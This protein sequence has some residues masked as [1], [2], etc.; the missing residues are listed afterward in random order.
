[1]RNQT[2][3]ILQNLHSFDQDGGNPDILRG[4]IRNRQLVEDKSANSFR[5]VRP[6]AFNQ[7]AILQTSRMTTRITP[8]LQRTS[9]IN[10]QHHLRDPGGSSPVSAPNSHS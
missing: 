10:S 6:S 4:T 3:S 1:M 9:A 7:R 5:L 8:L 2:E